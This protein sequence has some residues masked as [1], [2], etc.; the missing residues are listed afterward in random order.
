MSFYEK[1]LQKL[2]ADG[3]LNPAL[4][5]LV[6]GGGHT[7]RNALLATGFSNVT[8]SNLDDRLVSDEFAP[9]AWSFQDAEALDYA[10]R[11]FAQVIEHAA[12]HHCASPHRA[13]TEMY[14]VAER[15]VLAFEARDGALMRLGKVFGLTNDY[16]VEAVV[17]NGY[18]YGGWK[19]TYIPNYVYRWTEREVEKTIASFDPTA[20]PT[21][22]Y[23]YGLRLPV[24]RLAMGSGVRSLAARI[25]ALPIRAVFLVAKRQGNEF[26]FLV[27]KPTSK[28]PWLQSDD[29]PN[30]EWLGERYKA[31]V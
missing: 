14:R 8:I 20:Q 27:V 19:N 15:T 21:T 6:V 30:R 22:E 3:V 18:E 1:T 12:L 9:Y 11:S 29:T 2:I 28:H 31:P 7:D 26:G 17:A 16:E 24:A 13:L 4:P 25:L 10:D 5:T 23:F